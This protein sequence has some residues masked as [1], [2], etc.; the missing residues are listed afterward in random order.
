[1]WRRA[2]RIGKYIIEPGRFHSPWMVLAGLGHRRR[3][4]GDDVEQ[5][6]EAAAA[7]L[8]ACPHTRLA[9]APEST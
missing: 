7:D 2:R 1:M 9:R 3:A 6:R 4:S 5:V 8:V